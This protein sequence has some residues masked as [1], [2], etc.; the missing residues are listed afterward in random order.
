[1]N[2]SV[3][4]PSSLVKPTS[5]YVD[6]P[7]WISGIPQKKRSGERDYLEIVLVCVLVVLAIQAIHSTSIW[8]LAWVGLGG[9]AL[10][11]KRRMSVPF[12]LIVEA[13]VFHA[14]LSYSATVM[15]LAHEENAFDLV[16]DPS[17]NE[18]IWTAWG[19]MA[20]YL[21]GLAWSLGKK[22]GQAREHPPEIKMTEKQ[23]V[24]LCVFGLICNE[25]FAPVVPGS[26]RVVMVVFGYA[27]PL[28]LFI[29]LKLYTQ[30]G[31][32]WVGTWKFFF[33]VTT[34]VWWAMRSVAGGIFGSTILI[35]FI[36]MIQFVQ[37]S[38]LLLIGFCLCVG[39]LAPTIQDTKSDYRHSLEAE[40]KASG[41]TLKEVFVVNFKEIFIKGDF[42]TYREGITALAYRLCTFDIW[43][44]VKQHMDIHRDF[45]GGQTVKDALITSFTPRVFWPSKPITGGSS[46]LA[47]QYADMMLFEGTSVGVGLISEFYINGGTWAVLTGMLVIGF[48]AG[49]VLNRGLQ[50]SVQPLGVMMAISVIA[51][52]VR[53]EA[54]LS[55]VLGGIV[56]LIFLWWMLR[57]W[58]LRLY[59][60]S[61]R[62]LIRR[63]LVGG[64]PG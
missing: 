7:S 53:P 41:R 29:L 10:A 48:L 60:R 56:R 32:H 28:A 17:L 8:G 31:I 47:I 55:D 11:I 51:C 4:A 45:A 15:Y 22:W 5:G 44:R 50:D 14:I 52:L 59:L 40:G 35:L 3:P 33:W 16:H 62:L 30:A 57:A 18:A 26:I 2:P 34:L 38:R 25:I 13:P 64:A 27:A 37:K 39:I 54:N 21:L 58:V 36:F 24:A 61:R 49:I 1:M 23:A 9:V 46:D 19:G 12:L 42:T 6:N 63:G 20:C 43:Q